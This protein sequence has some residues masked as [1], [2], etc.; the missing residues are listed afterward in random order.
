[1]ASE[2]DAVSRRVI[3][4]SCF[5]RAA[6]GRIDVWKSAFESSA[7]QRARIPSISHTGLLGQPRSDF[8]PSKY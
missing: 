5:F 2:R 3:R 1:M 6:Y 7:Y 4:A 8:P